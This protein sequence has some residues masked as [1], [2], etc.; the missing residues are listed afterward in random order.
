MDE[1]YSKRSRRRRYLDCRAELRKILVELG[2]LC[3][4]RILFEPVAST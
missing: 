3:T 4:P 2:F 1:V